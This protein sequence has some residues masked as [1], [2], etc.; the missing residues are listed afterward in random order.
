LGRT[1]PVCPFVPAAIEHDGLWLAPE[2]VRTLK[3]LEVANLI[4]DYKRLFLRI[5]PRE[6]ARKAEKTIVV[7]FVDLP[8][9]DA[10]RYVD[11]VQHAKK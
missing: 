11:E 9:E 5:A 1:G 2:P 10:K 4:D 8:A 6:E 3:Q 7:V